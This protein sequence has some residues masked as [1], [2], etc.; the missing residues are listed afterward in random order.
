MAALDITSNQ[1]TLILDP[2]DATIDSAFADGV[3]IPPST[4]VLAPLTGYKTRLATAYKVLSRDSFRSV[5]AAFAATMGFDKPG[6]GTAATPV[7]VP[8]AKITGGGTDGSLTIVG[9]LIVARVN[10]T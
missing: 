6:L 2:V 9:G 7:V 5:L 1:K 8:L 3:Q 4:A 10:P